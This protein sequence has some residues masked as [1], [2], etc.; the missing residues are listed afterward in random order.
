VLVLAPTREI[1]LQASETIALVASALPVPGLSC[2]SFIGGLPLQEDE[3]Q[4]RRQV[5]IL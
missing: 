1:A 4:L 3:K 5:H 2:G